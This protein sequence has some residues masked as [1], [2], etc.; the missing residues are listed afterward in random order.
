M[1]KAV[2][3]TPGTTSSVP[4]SGPRGLS[5]LL[6]RTTNQPVMPSGLTPSTLPLVKITTNPDQPRRAFDEE[7]MQ[8]LMASIRVSGLL[9]PVIVKTLPPEKVKDGIE[10]M[11]VAGERRFRAFKLLGRSEIP[12]LV[13]VVS[14]ER[15]LLLLSLIENIQRTDLNLMEEAQ[16]F[17]ALHTT[18][19]MTQDQISQTVGKSRSMVT[20]L[21]RLVDLPQVV[22][23]ALAKGTLTLSHALVLAGLED[24]KLL[25]KIASKAIAEGLT[26]K[27]LTAY[28]KGDEK[29]LEAKKIQKSNKRG[30]V[31][32]PPHIVRLEQN[33]RRH[34]GTRVNIV[35]APRKGKIVI[36]FYS[37]EDFDR[38][39]KLMGVTKE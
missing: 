34:F 27:E 31:E 6:Q 38:I 7:A 39:T 12:A 29:Q 28:V 8:E 26:T 3:N 16:A 36:E 18:F 23:D 21:L 33:L 13:K 1:D 20:N 25:T 19:A 32:K 9:Q 24:K 2:P 15:D 4:A 37:V 35:E 10:Y 17:R 14:T 22:Q 5:A 11:L 30:Y